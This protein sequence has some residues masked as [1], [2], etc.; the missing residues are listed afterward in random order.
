MYKRRTIRNG[1]FVVRSTLFSVS[2]CATSS[3][4]IITSFRNILIAYK[5]PVAFSLQRITFPNVPFPRTF[6]NSKFSSVWNERSE[7]TLLNIKHLA[8]QQQND[9][10]Y[11]FVRTTFFFPVL[12]LLDVPWTLNFADSSSI[13]PP[14][15]SDDTT[16][17]DPHESDLPPPEDS[18]STS[19][20]ED[21]CCICVG[22]CWECFSLA[23]LAATYLRKGRKKNEMMRKN[24]ILYKT[25]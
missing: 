17:T 16:P 20:D 10:Y 13:L 11:Y 7:C 23:N 4:R 3:L 24:R 6:K 12:L 9:A 18:M 2:V 5:W 19:S 21:E 15:T 8:N 1:W 25:F 14:S 22:C